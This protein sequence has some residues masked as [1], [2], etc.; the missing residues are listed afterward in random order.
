M[1]TVLMTAE[2]M[3]G[4]HAVDFCATVTRVM[5]C[6]DLIYVNIA[7]QTLLQMYVVSCVIF[8]VTMW[9]VQSIL[10]HISVTQQLLCTVIRP[11]EIQ[12]IQDAR[13]PDSE[14]CKA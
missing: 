2:T 6:S 12:N 3:W 14:A 5:S 8:N 4:D 10:Y 13:K 1:T 7:C 11:F 9:T